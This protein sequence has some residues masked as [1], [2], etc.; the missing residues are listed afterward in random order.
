MKH[1]FLLL[2]GLLL[3]G[4]GTL[5]LAAHPHVFLDKRVTVLL[6]GQNLRGL[7]MEWTFD[8]MY[9]S[10]LIQDFDLDG[11]GFFSSAEVRDIQR[12]AFSNLENYGYFT[13]LYVDGREQ[14]RIRQIRDFEAEIVSGRRI[15]Y[16]F[17]VP[18]HQKLS[19]GSHELILSVFD[20]T[21]F[22]AFR[23]MEEQPVDCRGLEDS[24]F[25]YIVAE[26]KERPFY[27]DPQAGMS[28]SFDSSVYKPGM[29]TMYPEEMVFTFEIP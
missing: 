14:P 4:A 28:Q 6:E 24:L 27:Y 2:M 22:S 7:R 3:L 29:L 23:Y 21:C 8:A 9:S 19:S 5:R 15:R 1:K 11:D 13:R 26:N 16:I 20:T 18:L 12:G 10:S 25:S 17:T